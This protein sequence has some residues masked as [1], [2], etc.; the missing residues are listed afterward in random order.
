MEPAMKPGSLAVI[1]PVDPQDIRV[2]DVVT[3]RSGTEPNMPTTHRVIEVMHNDESLMFGTKGDANEDP[4]V[5][6]VPAEDVL[7]RVWLSVPYVGYAMD[8]IKKPLGLGLL[9]GIPTALIVGI[10]LKNIF[11]AVS[12]LRRKGHIKQA[13]R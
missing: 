7:G 1:Q 4:D 3:Y 10:E 13:S 8:F 2:G 5:N 11:S 6:A 12:G 9:I